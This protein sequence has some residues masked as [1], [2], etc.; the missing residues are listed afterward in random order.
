MYSPKTEFLTRNGWKLPIN[1]TTTDELASYG[2]RSRIEWVPSKLANVSFTKSQVDLH[3]CQVGRS[4]KFCVTSDHPVRFF[5]NFKEDT[6]TFS[7]TL[8]D[9]T[10]KL[11]CSDHLP[12]YIPTTFSTSSDRSEVTGERALVF[13]MM[14]KN[15]YKITDDGNIYFAISKRLSKNEIIDFLLKNGIKPAMISMAD[16]NT[17]VCF[18]GWRIRDIAEAVI[19]T[20]HVL[21]RVLDDMLHKVDSKKTR[22]RKLRF[23]C[24]NVATVAQL[25]TSFGGRNSKVVYYKV[26]K[27]NNFVLVVEPKDGSVSFRNRVVILPESG[28]GVSVSVQHPITRYDGRII[29]L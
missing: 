14:F 18:K 26:T 15:I 13:A 11:I 27:G 17:K 20:P 9:I 8:K 22:T 16:N 4:G 29:A 10:D 19:N 25:A 3:E 12:G 28:Q 6:V 1:I 7:L 2:Y 5:S 21:T 24:R 23:Y